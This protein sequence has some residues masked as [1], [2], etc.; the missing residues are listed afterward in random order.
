MENARKFSNMPIAELRD[1][2]LRLLLGQ[3]LHLEVIVPATLCYLTA[4]PFAGGDFEDGALIRTLFVRVEKEFW[5]KHPALFR[6]A[7]E[8]LRQGRQKLSAALASTTDEEQ[9]SFLREAEENY[10]LVEKEIDECEK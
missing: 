2:G 6:L 1:E 5:K 3:N 8:R 9:L 10:S 4:Q 7:I